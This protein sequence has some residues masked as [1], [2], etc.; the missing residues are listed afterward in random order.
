MINGTRLW[1]LKGTQFVQSNLTIS[2]KK[3]C[4]RTL[5]LKMS[6]LDINEKIPWKVQALVIPY[7]LITLYYLLLP[8]SVQ[9][10]FVREVFTFLQIWTNDYTSA[11]C[12]QQKESAQLIW[13]LQ[14]LPTILTLGDAIGPK[15][16]IENHRYR[17]NNRL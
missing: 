16:I 11:C 1:L 2:D 8:N 7:F 13:A 3:L 15:K 10:I 14:F 6:L 12:M 5:K 9:L 17:R 4:Y